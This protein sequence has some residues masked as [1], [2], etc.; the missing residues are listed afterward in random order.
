MTS[1]RSE[2]GVDLRRV[3]AER[4]AHRT[5]ARGGLLEAPQGGVEVV[6]AFVDVARVEPLLDARRVDLDREA[7]HAGH[8]G[9]ERL[10]PPHPAEPRRQH[11][12]LPLPPPLLGRL[13]RAATNVSYVPCR[14]PCVPM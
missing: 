1:R 2:L 10:R 13:A 3:A 14:I 7:A 9:R 4:D 6:D 5:L 12:Q 11:R 8:R